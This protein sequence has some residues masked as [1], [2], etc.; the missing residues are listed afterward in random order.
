MYRYWVRA[1]ETMSS[2]EGDFQA[3][4]SG[5]FVSALGRHARAIVVADLDSNAF[6]QRTFSCTFCTK[7]QLENSFRMFEVTSMAAGI[8]SLGFDEGYTKKCQDRERVPSSWVTSGMAIAQ[9]ARKRIPDS[10]RHEG[11]Q[12]NYILR[13]CCG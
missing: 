3:Q 5:S 13:L 1:K 12:H 7:K 9:K 6:P 11:G 10:W 4:Q 8:P 2:G